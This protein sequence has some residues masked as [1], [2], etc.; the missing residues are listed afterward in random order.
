MYRFHVYFLVFIE[1]ESR[2]VDG[3]LLEAVEGQALA[4][5]PRTSVQ[6]DIG[7]KKIQ[8]LICYLSDE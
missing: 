7:L 5:M 2:L 6:V 8:K 4:D 1:T 3:H